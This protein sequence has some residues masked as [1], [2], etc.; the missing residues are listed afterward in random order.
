M[1]LERLPYNRDYKGI[2]GNVLAIRKMG[3]PHYRCRLGT[4]PGGEA[5]KHLLVPGNGAAAGSD[6]VLWEAQVR[7]RGIKAVMSVYSP[8]W[9]CAVPESS[10][11]LLTR[12][13]WAALHMSVG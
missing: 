13:A 9:P 4:V 8:T 5:Q 2:L 12:E 11:A 10:D 1:E 3:R 7:S 6:A